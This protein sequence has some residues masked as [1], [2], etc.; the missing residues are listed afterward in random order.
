[1]R[2]ISRILNRK[3]DVIGFLLRMVMF[4]GAMADGNALSTGPIPSVVKIANASWPIARPAV[5]A[6]R[7]ISHTTA[8]SASSAS[9]D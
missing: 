8:C 6:C 4:R 1:M 2:E 3:R 5:C 9:P 7:H